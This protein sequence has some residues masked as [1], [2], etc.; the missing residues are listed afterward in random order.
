MEMTISHSVADIQAG[1]CAQ[2]AR[3]GG[4]E[5]P[6]NSSALSLRRSRRHEG[7]PQY[8]LLVRDF[9][10]HDCDRARPAPPTIML[11]PR[12]LYLDYGHAPHAP[13]SDAKSIGPTTSSPSKSA[14]HS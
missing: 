7:T 10:S 2:E 6:K 14:G 4:P 11:D 5:L 9:A 12:S 3:L 8:G 1:G 13:S